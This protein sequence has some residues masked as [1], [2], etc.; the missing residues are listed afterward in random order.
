[1]EKTKSKLKRDSKGRFV[2]GL[3]PFYTGKKMPMISRENHYAWKGGSHRVTREIAREGGK[4][5]SQCAI[6]KDKDCKLV[7]HHVDGNPQN[8]DLFNLGIVCHYC[9]NAI[10]GAGVKTRF[11]KGH[12]VPQ[13]WRNKISIANS[14]EVIA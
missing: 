9:H 3:I 12:A 8:N 13:G 14:K 5:F 2:K 4:D 7:V 10:H 1:M 6:C 11:Q